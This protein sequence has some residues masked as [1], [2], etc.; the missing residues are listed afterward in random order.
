MDIDIDVISSFS[1]KEI[2]PESVNASIFRDGKLTQH[3]CGVYFQ[4]IPKDPLTGLSAIP[5]NSAEDFGCF[6]I[7]F[8][9]VHVYDNFKSRE[10]IHE[11]LKY[12]PDWDLLQIPSVVSKLFQLSK[13]YEI[14]S[15]VKPRSVLEVADC[16]S[17]IRPGKRFMLKK[18]L[19]NPIKIRKELYKID[20]GE[21]IFKKSHACSYALIIVLQ[22]HLIKF[23]II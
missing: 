6:K 7:D 4:D 18:Y 20:D 21:F 15:Q 17:L 11:L 13:H 23:G 5:Y 14:I 3:P 9:H 12:E 22:L 1:S 16:L 8:L 10:E 2:F 19:E